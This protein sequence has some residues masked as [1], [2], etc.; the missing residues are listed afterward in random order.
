MK[1]ALCGQSIVEDFAVWGTNPQTNR[2]AMMHWDCC[3]A[4]YDDLT[5]NEKDDY[6]D[7]GV[8]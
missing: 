6:N 2:N 7:T 1:C 8:S 3:Q 4:A 5:Q